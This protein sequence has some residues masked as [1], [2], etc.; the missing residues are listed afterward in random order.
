MF[1][2]VIRYPYCLHDLL[3]LTGINHRQRDK[4]SKVVEVK[5]PK[6]VPEPFSSSSWDWEMPEMSPLQGI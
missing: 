6:A 5:S 2:A 1:S 3:F 4:G